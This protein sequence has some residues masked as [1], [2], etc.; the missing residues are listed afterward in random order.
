MYLHCNQ[1][2]FFK[3]LYK[4]FVLTGVITLLGGCGSGS[5]PTTSQKNYHVLKSNADAAYSLGAS[6]ENI[7]VSVFD[8]G[9]AADHPN[10]AGKVLGGDDFLSDHNPKHLQDNHGHGTHIAGLIAGAKTGADFHGI[11]YNAK[12]LSYRMLRGNIDDASE[13]FATEIEIASGYADALARGSYIYNNS[14]STK[15]DVLDGTTVAQLQNRKKEFLKQAR[16]N[17]A[18]GGIY[19]FSASNRS[20][21]QVS[22]E[23]GLP[24][25][26]NDLQPGWLAVAALDETGALAS[27]SSACG[28]AKAWCLATSG[29]ETYGMESLSPDGGTSFQRGTSISTAIVSG[30]LALLLDTFGSDSFTAQDAAQRLLA[31]ANKTGIYS[32]SDKYG[33]GALDIE[34]A[35]QPIGELNIPAGGSLTSH[36]FTPLSSSSLFLPQAAHNTMLEQFSEQSILIVDSFQ[37]VPFLFP[38]DDVLRSTTHT[39]PTLAQHGHQSTA[40]LTKWYDQ[41][42][43]TSLSISPTLQLGF[44]QQLQD[45]FGTQNHSTQLQLHWQPM[46]TPLYGMMT[47]TLNTNAKTQDNALLETGIKFSNAQLYSNLATNNHYAHTVAGSGAFKQATNGLLSHGVRFKNSWA[48]GTINT[49]LVVEQSN[50]QPSQEASTSSLWQW[51]ATNKISSLHLSATHTSPHNPDHTIGTWWQF[52][53]YHGD[54]AASIKLPY[55]FQQDSSILYKT[56]AVSGASLFKQQSVGF[57]WQWQPSPEWELK[58]KIGTTHTVSGKQSRI[59]IELGSA[60]G[61]H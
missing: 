19:V 50:W 43:I 59:Q 5:L 2:A 49:N 42:T 27:L 30:G 39:Y 36:P 11:A 14:W 52:N 41:S 21:P 48:A 9:I 34:A 35:M 1:Q 24:Y 60:L 56:I 3:R 16:I 61:H 33:Q 13:G 40:T 4:A 46:H 54:T 53:H 28:V 51:Q 37:S 45:D 55:A 47:Y 32:D 38:V 8:T 20:Q 6:G 44:D 18:A 17:I 58:T 31:S 57:F 23:A 7:I 10:L 12:L 25:Y 26:F 15:S 22:I 29:G